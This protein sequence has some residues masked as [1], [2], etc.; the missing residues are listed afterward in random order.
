MSIP[1]NIVVKV[2]S[3]N[4]SLPAVVRVDNVFYKI[5]NSTTVSQES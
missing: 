1:T 5:Q 3:I 4:N 2:N